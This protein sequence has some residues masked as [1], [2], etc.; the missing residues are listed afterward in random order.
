LL[1]ASRAKSLTGNGIGI[2]S[3]EAKSLKGLTGLV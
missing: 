1:N 2:T 3:L